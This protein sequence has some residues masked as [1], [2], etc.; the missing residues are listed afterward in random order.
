MLVNIHKLRLLANELADMPQ[1][2]RG[3]WLSLL[4][5]AKSKPIKYQGQFSSREI[6]EALF[7]DNNELNQLGTRKSTLYFQK[8]SYSINMLLRPWVQKDKENACA[9]CVLRTL[10]YWLVNVVK[11]NLEVYRIYE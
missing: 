4:F 5:S 7:L 11:R 10:I 3:I 8:F 2:H 9:V 1:E 6:S